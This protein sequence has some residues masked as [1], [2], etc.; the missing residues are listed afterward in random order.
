M[1]PL[2]VIVA[3]VEFTYGAQ[4]VQLVVYASR[5]LDLGTGGYGLLLAASGAGGLISAVFNGQLATS[6]R[7]DARCA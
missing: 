6:R 4:T 2:T 7:L 1:I 5:S 3:M